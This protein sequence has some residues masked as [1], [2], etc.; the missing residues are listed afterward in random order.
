[1][2]GAMPGGSLALTPTKLLI[3]QILIVF[4]I[5]IAGL[6]A[7]TQW[8][9]AMLAYQ[10]ELGRPWA[11]VDGMP[12]YRPWALFVW[13]YHF[14]AYAPAG[15]SVVHRQWQVR[16]GARGRPTMSPLMARRAGQMPARSIGQGCTPIQAS[17]LGAWATG[18]FVIQGL[19]TSW[20]SRQRARVRASAL[21][22]RPCCHGPDR[23]W[24][25]TLRARTGH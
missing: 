4:A 25:T 19:S 22:S 9:A 17:C 3:G 6:W 2:P 11:I 16:S 18:I 5:V 8:A 1:L 12:L 7:A 10:P 15:F 23:R 20:P 14:D 13:W 21:S 24:S